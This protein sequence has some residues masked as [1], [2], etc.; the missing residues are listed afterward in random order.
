MPERRGH[1]NLRQR[2]W[3]LSDV[4]GGGKCVVT[5]VVVTGVILQMGVC[6]SP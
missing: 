5:N 3:G 1:G 2:G 4:C 6:K